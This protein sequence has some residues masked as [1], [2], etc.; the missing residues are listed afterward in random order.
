[1]NQNNNITYNVYIN[2]FGA[3][4]ISHLSNDFTERCVM[5]LKKGLCDYIER[6]NFN[7]NVPENHNIR[8]ETN[9]IVRVKELDNTWRL[10]NLEPTVQTLIKNRCRELQMYYQTNEHLQHIDANT[11]F[12]IIRDHLH[13]L[14]TGV[15]KDIQPV[16]EYVVTLIR[17]LEHMYRKTN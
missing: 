9:R 15:K 12:N 1:M 6:V 10:R 17:E 13:V 7:P 16:Y 11:H 3:E 5:N 8:Y 4:N 14:M 2:N